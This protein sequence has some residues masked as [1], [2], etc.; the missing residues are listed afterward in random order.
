MG[1]TAK[2][3]T[4]E[5]DAENTRDDEFIDEIG[6]QSFP[7]SDPPPW[8]LGVRREDDDADTKHDEDRGEEP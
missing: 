4:D 3:S 1:D 7:A 6:R 5:G 8:T 2:P